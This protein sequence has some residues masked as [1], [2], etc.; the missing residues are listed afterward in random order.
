MAE[1]EQAQE[2]RL[3]YL[4]FFEVA[5]LK[6][7]ALVANLYEYA[8]ENS[9]PLKAGVETVEQTVKTVVGPVYHKIEGKPFELLEFVDKKVDETICK[10][11]G[12]LPPTVKQ[13]TCQMFDMAKQAPDV[14]RSVVNEVQ[15]TGVIETAS[16]KARVLYEKCEPT[17]KELYSKYEPVAEEWA[18]FAWHKLLKL[19]LFPQFVYIMMPTATYWSEKYN[20][21]VVYMSDKH[22]RIAAFLPYVPVEKIKKALERGLEENKG[23]K[24]EI[25]TSS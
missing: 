19:P 25:S 4:G 1:T 20:H 15:R 5:V 7:T 9:G 17:A 2:V 8:K 10:V 14:A 13:R 3:K 24:A 22:Y 12:T 6:A 21:I 11:D 16:E 18:L 23:G